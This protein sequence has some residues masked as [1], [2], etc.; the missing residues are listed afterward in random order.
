V[1]IEISPTTTVNKA[2]LTNPKSN[3]CVSFKLILLHEDFIVKTAAK[4]AVAIRIFTSNIV[5]GNL[6]SVIK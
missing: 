5:P 4:M 6:F 2:I 3:L 1:L